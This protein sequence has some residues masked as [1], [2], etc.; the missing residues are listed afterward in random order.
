M[1]RYDRRDNRESL[2]LTASNTS[3]HAT[4]PTRSRTLLP[5]ILGVGI[6][7]NREEKDPL[8][9]RRSRLSTRSKIHFLASKRWREYCIYAI[10]L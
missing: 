10:Q 9:R 6:V 4:Y 3:L 7:A 8:Q 1:T 5:Q 2:P